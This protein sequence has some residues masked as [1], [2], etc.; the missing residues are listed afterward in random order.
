MRKL[1]PLLLALAWTSCQTRP[2]APLVSLVA[3]G[4]AVTVHIQGQLFTCYSQPAGVKK[5]VLYPVYSP[6]GQLI[7]R[8]WPLIPVAGE[9]TDH[10]HQVGVWMNHGEVNGYDFWNHSDSIP[11]ENRSRYGTILHHRTVSVHSGD[12]GLLE[13]QLH[14][15]GG[16][17]EHLITERVRFRIWPGD[18]AWFAERHSTLIAQ[19]DLHFGDSKEGFF[20]LRVATRLEGLSRETRL[21]GNTWPETD[22]AGARWS[23]GRAR[24]FDDAGR[25]GDS[26]WGRPVRWVGLNGW[27]D[28]R[29][30]AVSVTSHPANSIG[31]DRAMTRSYGLFS[32]NPLGRKVY[33]PAA[34]T[35]SIRVKAGDSLVFRYLLG[36]YGRKIGPAE[37]ELVSAQWTSGH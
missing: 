8:G 10:P 36:A 2:A 6:A 34:D 15:I 32:F 30:A 29:P 23:R 18:S 19:Q 21:P 26:V 3:S 35:L 7:T 22:S 12:T 28:G 31:P 37:L 5:P 13:V 27:L 17:G 33:D 20:A 14:W 24:Y 11:E 16:K 25:M 9:A 1:W 4:D